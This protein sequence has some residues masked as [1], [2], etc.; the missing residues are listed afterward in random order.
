MAGVLFSVSISL[1]VQGQQALPFAVAACIAVIAHY[2][3]GYI[4]LPRLK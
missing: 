1:H 3:Y 2:G 4:H